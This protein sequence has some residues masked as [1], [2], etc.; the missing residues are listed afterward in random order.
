[1]RHDDE[2]LLQ[3][4][5]DGGEYYS[6]D[7][8]RA[9]LDCPE[10]MTHGAEFTGRTSTKIFA[11]PTCVMKIRGEISFKPQ[12]AKRWCE[13]RIRREAALNLYHPA[14]TWFILV[15]EHGC[16]VGNITPRLRALH[17]LPEAEW[18]QHYQHLMGEFASLYFRAVANNGERLDEGLS[19]FA[20]AD[21]GHVYYLD[22]DLYTWDD[23]V[24]LAY[25]L[26]MII[27]SQAWLTVAITEAMGAVIAR[28]CLEDGGR[29]QWIAAL[30]RQLATQYLPQEQQ[31]EMLSAF[32]N[33]MGQVMRERTRAG[34]ASFR[35][36]YLAVV[37]DIHANQ[38]ALERVLD[39]LDQEQ[40][41]DI[42][43]LGDIV[44]YGPHPQVCIEHLIRRKAQVITGNHDYVCANG[45][46][47]RGFSPDARWVIE[48]SRE[49]L[50]AEH[51]QW[52]GELPRVYHQ[53]DWMAV[54]GAPV[55]PQ[56]FNAYV[57]AMTYEDNLQHLADMQ[58][59]FCFHGHSHIPGVFYQNT[60]KDGFNGDATQALS[61]YDQ[62]LLC[63]G[64]IGQPR[65]GI[66]G[67]E[68]AIFDR[69]GLE[70]RFKRLEYDVDPVL[71]QM[72]QQG[73][74]GR[75]VTRLNQG[76]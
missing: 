1:M 61:R 42:L 32:A 62:A 43:V 41:S 52:L 60:S 36:R 69:E 50:A 17:C 65:S 38:P 55:D 30:I 16:I 23:G 46:Y 63:P 59:R 11:S 22:D 64:S 21:D 73:F 27:R 6:V 71:N 4:A 76:R 70:W 51:L 72:R 37:G 20:V 45:D 54:H 33:G 34:R 35:Q 2:I 44:G 14:K 40:I 25:A 53:D 19:N 8:A 67:A 15:R 28:R 24:S 57:Y 18:R 49:R 66:A 29:S 75:L 10:A 12:E 13:T 5:L 48:W 58:V 47:P 74:P 56:Y 68:L 31:R 9:L 39:Y 3:P 26:S 7:E